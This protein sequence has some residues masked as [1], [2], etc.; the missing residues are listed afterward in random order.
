MNSFDLTTFGGAVAFAQHYAL[1]T[2]N[3]LPKRDG[4][5][6]KGPN[7]L[8][9]RAGLP[10]LPRPK[11]P[12]VAWGIPRYCYQNCHRLVA[13]SRRYLYAEGWALCPE[14][15]FPVPHAWVVDERDGTAHE[16]TMR[17]MPAAYLGLTF[18]RE[19]SR[20][21]WKEQLKGDG[22]CC[23]PLIDAWGERWP[24]LRLPP[25][26][27]PQVLASPPLNSSPEFRPARR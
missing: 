14:V 25:E 5:F 7:D 23:G 20:R 4:Y 2:T 15:P 11:P 10:M 18:R 6:F 3:L 24:L 9:L 22:D 21:R 12:R 19:Y 26:H 8:L 17:G 13:R 27:L 16:I 1:L